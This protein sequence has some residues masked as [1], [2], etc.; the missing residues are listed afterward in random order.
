MF[1]SPVRLYV[2]NAEGKVSSM[3]LLCRD[4]VKYIETE[5]Y[6]D[7]LSLPAAQLAA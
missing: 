1:A 6:T 5:Q 7:D 2:G 4:C 3:C